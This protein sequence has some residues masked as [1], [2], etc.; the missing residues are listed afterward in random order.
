MWEKGYNSSGFRWRWV[1][2][3]EWSPLPPKSIESSCSLFSS[4]SFFVLSIFKL[5][6]NTNLF[7]QSLIAFTNIHEVPISVVG[8][9]WRSLHPNLISVRYSKGL[10]FTFIRVACHMKVNELHVVLCG[11]IRRLSPLKVILS[12]ST[13]LL[14]NYISL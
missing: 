11:P 5:W 3:G 8:H 6:S 2:R 10:F 7:H 9:P 1:D 14:S 12:Y 13:T 4:R